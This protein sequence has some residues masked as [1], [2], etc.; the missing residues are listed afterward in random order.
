[1]DASPAPKR[2]PPP[3]RWRGA[4]S[5]PGLGA[6]ALL[7]LLAGC[8]SPPP[9]DERL[10]QDV[11]AL[12]EP[13]VLANEFSGAIVLM[14]DDRVVY[15]RGFGRAS[16]EPP[17]PFTPATPSDGG[18]L[19]KTFTAAGLWWLVH[20]GRLA[21]DSPVQAW[22]PEYP[23]A[24]VTVAQLLAHGNGLAPDYGDFDPHF[25]PGQAR[26]TA[27][28]LRIAGRLQPVPTFAP[29]SRF[30]YTNLGF[31][32]AGLLIERVTGRP[33][34]DFVQERFF[35]PAGFEHSFARPAHFAQWPVPRTRG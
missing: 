19:A 4:G 16:H 7:A 33:Y 29:G 20:E 32:A 6:L 27:A 35:R 3:R 24:G 25:Q 18:S 10:A 23:H 1:M 5:L 15:E 2:P 8:A 9:A 34:A 30:E 13:L 21:I 22:V 12:V 11:A 14:R 26:T 17:V 31:D 28:L